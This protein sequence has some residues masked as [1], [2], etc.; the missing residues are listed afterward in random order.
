MDKSD[1]K[2]YL[3]DILEQVEK[4]VE[5]QDEQAIEDLTSYI[6]M[7]KDIIRYYKTTEGTNPTA[8]KAYTKINEAEEKIMNFSRIKYKKAAA[9]FDIREVFNTFVESLSI[10][11]RG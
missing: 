5:A 2:G 1:L 4:V 6:H 7:S 9:P 11:S 3:K 10:F 8:E